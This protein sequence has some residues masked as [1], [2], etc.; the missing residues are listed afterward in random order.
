MLA[1]AGDNPEDADPGRDRDSARPAGR[2][3]AGHGRPVYPINPMAVARYRE[4]TRCR[5]RSP[6][7]SM[8]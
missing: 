7:T 4:R 8:R 5:G 3:V 1:E 2:G 6:T